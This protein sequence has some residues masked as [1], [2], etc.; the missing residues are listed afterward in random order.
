MK[1]VGLIF[2]FC[3]GSI[4][5]YSYAQ[6]VDGI[7]DIADQFFQKKQYA[8]AEQYYQKSYNISRDKSIL[9]RLA[10]SQFYQKKYISS[11]DYFKKVYQ[12][13]KQAD[14]LL[15][16]Y[17]GANYQYLGK[18]KKSNT[19]LKRFCKKNKKSHFPELKWAREKI[20]ANFVFLS[21]EDLEKEPLADL[22]R[23]TSTPFSEM[24]YQKW[25]EDTAFFISNID[26]LS[27][28][29][30]RLFIQS[31]SEVVPFLD[32]KI[33]QEFKVLG[34][35][36]LRDRS[37][38][39]LSLENV[40]NEVNDEISSF[41]FLPYQN[42]Q[43]RELQ[44]INL[45]SHLNKQLNI[46]LF[47]FE[48]DGRKQLLWASKSPKKE[49][50]YHL[51]QG[52]LKGLDL[53]N[54]Q[55]VN[56]GTESEYNEI[57][58]FYNSSNDE[59]FLASDCPQGRGGFDIYSV[60][61][62]MQEPQKR[63]LKPLNPPYNSAYDDLFFTCVQDSAFLASNRPTST[64]QEEVCCN[65]IYASFFKT[66]QLDSLKPQ[67]ED[68]YLEKINELLPLK[69]Y[70]DNDQPKANL[71]GSPEAMR[72]D[73]LLENYKKRQAEFITHYATADSEFKKQKE[74]AEIEAFFEKAIEDN[75]W[76]LL[77]FNQLL[78]TMMEKGMHLVLSLKG[79][80]SPLNSEKYNIQLSERRIQ[81][82]I[83]YYQYLNNGFFNSFIENKQMIFKPL[84]YGV[85]Q[86]E[87]LKKAK[88]QNVR[89]QV[90]SPTASKLRL[91]QIE[92]VITQKF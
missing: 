78:K 2:L 1:K 59:L 77:E 32:D 18:Y 20:A 80:A 51:F 92:A 26:S 37:G 28:R 88:N 38:L 89:M 4:C 87:V 73:V 76:K 9:F 79:Y 29:H 22:T 19:F 75:Y 55:K 23:L 85:V 30:N 84:P 11:L 8:V 68:Y 6:N 66:T 36:F 40:S 31:H 24:A 46:H 48:K 83:M 13:D 56:L 71:T 35:H 25:N 27:A 45:P 62:F 54:I 67:Q 39:M 47:Y 5:H 61:N 81:S 65:E 49:A 52:E 60:K 64:K 70:F 12:Y 42:H 3:I 44:K 41:Y 69:L 86:S 10:V 33:S 14:K 53:V 21:E 74:I 63:I 90:Y 43:W 82:I 91:V 15:Y 17:L 34:F 16:Y 50:G 58:P 7:I 57:S 72:Y